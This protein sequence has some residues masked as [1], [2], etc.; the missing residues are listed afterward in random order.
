IV[1]VVTQ[2]LLFYYGY[3]YHGKKGQVAKFIPENEKLEFA[4]TIIPVVV[5]ACLIIYGLFTWSDIM[6]VSKDEDTMVI[7]LYAYQFG[8]KARYAGED[9]TL[10]KA[11]VRF[12]EGVNSLGVDES[13]P[14]SDDDIVASELHL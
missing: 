13:D 14:Y 10:G 4:W 9:N 1:Q 3:K 8:W 12:I 5:L 7:E 2:F 11:N 6:N